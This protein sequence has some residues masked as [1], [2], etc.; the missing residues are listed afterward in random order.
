MRV[1]DLEIGD[2]VFIYAMNMFVYIEEFREAVVTKVS[3][4]RVYIQELG[5]DGSFQHTLNRQGNLPAQTLHDAFMEYRFLVT[6]DPE[7][8]NKKKAREQSH[9]EF[10][11][12]RN[13]I[14]R[15]LTQAQEE[16]VLKAIKRVLE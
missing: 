8:F 13:E 6:D 2:K 7:Y 5:D 9:K 15:N 12:K 14:T 11:S 16:A 1:K 3:A 10:V 4:T